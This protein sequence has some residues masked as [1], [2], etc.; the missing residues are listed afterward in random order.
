MIQT[1][2]IYKKFWIYSYIILFFYEILKFFPLRILAFSF[3]LSIFRFF[4]ILIDI[5]NIILINYFL[6]FIS[7]VVLM[8]SL[9][10]ESQLYVKYTKIHFS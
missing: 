9:D 10:C 4:R 3:L 2:S 8:C 1:F 6:C 7:L 5:V